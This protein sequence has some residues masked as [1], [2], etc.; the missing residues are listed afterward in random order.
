MTVIPFYTLPAD[1]MKGIVK[2]KLD[3]LAT[4]L[5]ENNK[6]KFVYTDAT[7]DQITNRCTEVETGAR[8]IDYILTGNIMPKMS[9]EILAHMATGGMPAEVH[10]DVGED[11]AFR[12]EF[13]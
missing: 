12:M 8:N 11:G 2:L 3:K 6:M 7:V 13:K 1:A 9:Q 10:L 4:R 5:M